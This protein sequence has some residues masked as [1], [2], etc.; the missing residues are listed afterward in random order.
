MVPNGAETSSGPEYQKSSVRVGIAKFNL[1]VVIAGSVSPYLCSSLDRRE[2]GRARP[3]RSNQ[4]K[5]RWCTD[6]SEQ[7]TPRIVSSTASIRKLFQPT[8]RT[9][10]WSYH[11]FPESIMRAHSTTTSGSSADWGAD[12]YCIS[13]QSARRD[14]MEGPPTD[15]AISSRPAQPR[16]YPKSG[17]CRYNDSGDYGDNGFG[18]RP[19]DRRRPVVTC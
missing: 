16:P 6:T 9:G 8:R 1:A 12:P 10:W 19:T 13:F 5:R 17:R 2:R 11:K 14:P 15:R 4:G 18:G 7:I 3:S